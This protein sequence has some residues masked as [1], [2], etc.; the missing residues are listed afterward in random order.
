MGI[1]MFC[2]LSAVALVGALSTASAAADG[3]WYSS[4]T[5]DV[6]FLENADNNAGGV[7]SEIDFDTGYGI[8]GA[9]G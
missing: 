3:S 9:V 8:D 2:G 1:R 5:G 6:V 7:V 4:L